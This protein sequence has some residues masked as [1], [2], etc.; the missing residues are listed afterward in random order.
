MPNG[1][2]PRATGAT[3]SAPGAKAIA[4]SKSIH[5]GGSHPHQMK[6]VP[7]VARQARLADFFEPM[8]A[9]ANEA[10]KKSA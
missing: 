5:F 9:H 6:R 2:K 4:P 8:F 1:L 3:G 7:L 10:I